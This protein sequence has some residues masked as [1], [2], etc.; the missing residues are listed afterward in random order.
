MRDINRNTEP[1]NSTPLR[2]AA[3]DREFRCLSYAERKMAEEFGVDPH[4]AR[5]L[6]AQA[7]G[8]GGRWL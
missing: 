7:Y 1:F 4:I 6:A 8:S 5:L 2:L 3:R